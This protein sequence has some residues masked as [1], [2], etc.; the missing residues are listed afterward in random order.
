MATHARRRQRGQALLV[1]L[2]F[3]AA[4][5]I[6][7]WAALTLASAAFLGLSSVRADTRST[8]ALDAGV[9]YAIQ[10]E[11]AS[12]KALGCT[13]DLGKQLVLGAV[14]VNVDVTPVAGCKTNKPTYTVQVTNLAGGRLL[15]AQI[16]SSNAGKKAS[17]IIDWEAYQ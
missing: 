7:L 11:D 2:V 15:N 9:E 8:Y 4:F 14:T 1:I 17:W 5:L 16:R 12:A 3:V 6:V 10:L 13:S